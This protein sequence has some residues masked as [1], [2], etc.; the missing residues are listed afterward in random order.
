MLYIVQQVSV[1]ID[2]KI[3]VQI[4]PSPTWDLKDKPFSVISFIYDITNDSHM[5]HIAYLCRGMF[6]VTIK[7]VT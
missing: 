4:S 5:W 2:V 7:T 1:I 6:V 3:P